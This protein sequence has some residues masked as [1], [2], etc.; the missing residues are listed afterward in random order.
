MAALS[1]NERAITTARFGVARFG[2]TRFGYTPDKTQ[3][4]TPGS[5][6]GIYIWRT[7]TLPTTTW[8]AVQS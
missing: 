8:T 3:G 1:S 6:G 4:T 7:V 2:A 5:A